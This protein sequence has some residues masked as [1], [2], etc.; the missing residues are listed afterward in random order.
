MTPLVLHNTLTRAKEEFAPADGHH[1]KMYCCGP[2]VYNYAHIG[3]LRTYVFEDILHRA[4]KW[5]GWGLT[6]VM[7]ITDVGHMTSDAD[8]GEDKM[9]K[10]AARENRSP[11]EI[12][13]FYEDA[14][15]R[16]CARLNI[17]R[18]D[19][20]PRAT[21]HVPQMIALIQRLEREGF[22]YRTAEGIY[23]D[24][25][26]D[27]DYGKLAGL[28]LGAQKEGAR[29]DVNTD[30]GKRHPADFILW[31]TNKPT[32][33]M[34]WESPWGT[35]YPGWHIECSAMSMEYLG[36]TLDIHGGGIDHIPVHNT[37]EI[38][39]SECATGHIF[40]RFWVHGAFLTLASGA[41]TGRTAAGKMSKSAEN[42]L[43]VQKL[44]DDSFDPLAYR[45][46][47]LTAHYRS[48]LAFSYDSLGG[49]TKALGKIYELRA[50][51]GES[52]D[53]LSD[54][55][56]AALRHAI[57]EAINDDLNI[58]KAV[59]ILHQANSYRLWREFDPILGLD[60]EARSRAELP[61]PGTEA[62]PAEVAALARQRDAAR[63]ARD[64]A[65]SDALRAQ[66]E[67]MGYTVGDS[68]AGTVVKKKL[69]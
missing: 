47:C 49:A 31:F 69:L 23:F 34:Q 67:D 26:K 1:V 15:F 56:Y 20:A 61:A 21:E 24:T 65:R 29:E 35:G 50:R 53:G 10:A 40:A 4:L 45:Y 52:G 2:T 17:I 43:T 37:N 68:P 7:N 9:A 64:Y 54:A 51:V 13:R 25:A 6:H 3:N 57:G 18:P 12:A 42:F 36:E 11:W 33:I 5:H 63:Q 14:F 28:N 66:I 46:L 30:P 58:P 32:H 22:T 44:I 59:G 27:A 41:V 39:Q 16:D 48:E 8:A 55:E 62:L 19:V 60:I 38:A